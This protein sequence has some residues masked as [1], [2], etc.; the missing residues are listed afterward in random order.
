MLIRTAS[1]GRLNAVC[2]SII[3]NLL[4][5]ELLRKLVK[6][7]SLKEV[8]QILKGTSYSKFII[9]SSKSKLLKGI[10]DYFYYLLNKLYKIYPLEELKE[11]FLVRDRGIVLE[12]VLKNKELKNFGL[13]Y[14]DFLNVITVFKYRIIEGLSVEKVAPYLFTKGSLKNLLPQM[15]RAS[16]LKELSRVLPFPKE[17]KSYG[18][19]R[20]EIFLFHV[21][22]L[23]KLLLGYPFK[24]VIS[25]VILRLKEIE[26]MNLTAIIEGISGNFNREEIEEMIVDIS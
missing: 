4:G 21:S 25:F 14:A 16:S 17:P 13:V 8:S 18:E 5:T 10:N 19:F 26:K 9:G 2:R 7:G 3:S 20:K 24:P 22:S 15:L 1:L 23:R 12:K 6:T 11:F